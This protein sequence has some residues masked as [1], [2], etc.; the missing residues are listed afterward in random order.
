MIGV[1]D[2]SVTNHVYKC[3]HTPPVWRLDATTPGN[4]GTT[5]WTE[6]ILHVDMDSF[7]VEVERL[8]NPD[9][10]GRPV[11]VG[12]TGARG[13]VASASYEAR[14]HGVSSAQPTAIAR[15]LCP[16]LTVVAPA[17]GE[18]REMSTR[19]FE[20]FR[21]FTPKVESLSLDEAF[22]DVGGL[23]K[24]SASPVEVGESV[25]SAIKRGLGLPSSVGVAGNKLIAKLASEAAKPDGLRHVPVD[26]QLDFLHVLP[27]DALWG[28]GPAT[29]AGLE[30]LGVES[31]GDIAELPE[32]ALIGALGPAQGRY[33]LELSNGEDPRPVQPDSEAK[34]LSV[35]ETYDED[36]EG[37][38]LIQ[39]ALLAHA[40]RLSSRLHRAG[41]AGRTI[42]LKARYADFTTVTRSQTLEHPIDGSREIYRSAL[43]LVEDLDVDRPV[44]LLGLGAT[45]LADSD[46]PRQLDLENGPEWSRLEEAVARVRERYGEEAVSPARLVDWRE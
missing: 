34:S 12:G 18:Y 4:F 36:V 11:A 16:Q 17:H 2:L 41:L 22:L 25:R 32:A 10:V 37:K 5:V 7:F 8:K 3:S 28:V 24:H 39:S 9:L 30:R 35:E 31:V 38:S 21:S 27:A 29:L 33:L 43:E 19:V 14:T 20:V 23:S 13:V 42:T 1:V 15:R 46:E 45:S 26:G 40:Q 6:P 44:R